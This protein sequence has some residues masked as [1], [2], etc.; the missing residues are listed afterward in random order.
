VPVRALMIDD[1][2]KLAEL[3]RT[4]LAPNDV[5]LTHA[6]DGPRGLAA[7]ARGGFDVVILDVMMPGLDGL[8]VLRR[9]RESSAVPVVMLTA[10]GDEA[11]RVVGLELGA[12]DYLAKPVYP[13]EL[14][15]RIRAV[16]RR[17][18]P[19]T[20]DRTLVIGDLELD[21]EGR[22][23]RIGAAPLPLTAL[24]YDLLLALA[25]RAGRVVSRE[26]LWEA[27]GRADTAVSDRTVDVHVMHLRQKLGDDGKEP[28][29]LK[30]VRGQGYVLVREPG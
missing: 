27:A 6:A 24:E 21:P 25:E 13:R 7:V 20:P 10:R 11:D 17:A 22:T 18:G 15:A 26:A 23:A 9:L 1:D 8:E 12:D 3:L 30:T 29:R 16:L 2:P 28:R 5:V 4:Y 19:R 14:L